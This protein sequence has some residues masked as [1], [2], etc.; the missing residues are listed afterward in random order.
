MGIGQTIVSVPPNVCVEPDAHVQLG[1]V[2]VRGQ[3][4]DGVDPEVVEDPPQTDAPRLV[5][6]SEVD[7]GALKVSD[8]PPEE[9]RDDHD[10]FDDDDESAAERAEAQRACER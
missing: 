9:L 4:S 6:D 3:R 1:D 8:R 10:G 7:V 5:L 2:Y